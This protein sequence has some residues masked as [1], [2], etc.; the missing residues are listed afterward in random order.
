MN[1]VIGVR[2]VGKE[3]EKV[4]VGGGVGRGLF[5]SLFRAVQLFAHSPD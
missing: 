1:W 4:F 3:W 2:R 5:T